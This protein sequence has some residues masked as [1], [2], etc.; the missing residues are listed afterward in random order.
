MS[1][2]E[3][4]VSIVVPV[5]NAENYLSETFSYLMAQTWKNYEVIFVDDCSTD[6]SPE[7]LEQFTHGSERFS[8]IRQEENQGC[9]A[10]RNAGLAMASGEYAICLDSDDWYAADLIER[11][12][13]ALIESDADVAVCNSVVIHMQTGERRHYGQ[14]RRLMNLM[15]DADTMAIDQPDSYPGI[16]DLIDYVA[17]SKMFRLSYFKEKNLWFPNLKYYEDIPFAFLS[18]LL[19][20]KIIFVKKPLIHYKMQNNNSMSSWSFPKQYYMI[21]AFYHVWRRRDDMNWNALRDNFMIRVMNNISSMAKM[22]FDEDA[23]IIRDRIALRLMKEWE[24]ENL[25]ENLAAGKQIIGDIPILFHGDS[26]GICALSDPLT[27]S[28]R[29]EM[30][31]LKKRLCKLGYKP[32][33]TSNTDPDSADYGTENRILRAE[34]LMK[35]YHDQDISLIFD[36]SGGN[37]SNEILPYLDYEW[38]RQSSRIFSGYSDLTCI[39]NA[40]YQKT[41]VPSIL[42][43]ICNLYKDHFSMQM[44]WFN[45][46]FAQNDPELF[47]FQVRFYRGTQ[48][49]GIVVGGNIRC[50]LKLAGTEYWPDME[51]KLLFLESLSTDC[52]AVHAYLAQLDQLGVFRQVKGVIIGTFGMGE[53]GEMKETDKIFLDILPEELPLAKTREIGHH[54]LSKALWIGKELS[55]QQDEEDTIF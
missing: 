2:K 29:S 30:E 28:K 34:S 8:W 15:E 27:D 55:L 7:I 37:M 50:L 47:R 46:T 5:Y 1:L 10:A 25:D 4:L 41:G 19:A 14:W 6:S 26:I 44:E 49:Q 31:D 20:D 21:D 51:G 17:W 12:V 52:A 32:V 36:V 13:S 42:Y 40:I 48:M 24:I 53:E 9:G 18:C 39:I 33:F 16:F 54:Y 11:M 3:P 22:T 38:I 35:L 43:R 45:R 23:R